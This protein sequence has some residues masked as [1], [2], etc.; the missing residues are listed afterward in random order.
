MKDGK[1]VVITYGTFDLFH[2]GH[3]NI[4]KRAREYGD[5]LIV[6]V[7]GE[8]YDM[9]RGKLSVHDS[10]AERI[11]NVMNTDL[12]D[13]IIIEEYLGQKIRDIIKYNVDVFVLG[14]DWRGKLL[15]TCLSASHEG[16]FKYA[17]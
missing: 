9:G 10:I 13:E 11:N 3:Y 12:V 6:G 8:S 4:L 15:R 7:T 14:D 2:K 17:A 1:R 16:Y 5:Y